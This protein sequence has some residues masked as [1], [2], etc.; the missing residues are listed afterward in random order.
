[1]IARLTLENFMAHA[2]TELELGPGV[3][4]LTGPNNVGKSAVVE[5]LRCLTQN[6]APRHVIRHG[7]KEARVS[8]ELDDG[9]R[10]VWI[11]KKAGAGYQL[12]RPGAEAPEEFWKLGRGGVPD[13]VREALRLETVA[14]ENRDDAI[15]VHLGNQRQPIFLLNEPPS[16][17]ASFFAAS[18]ESAHLLAMQDALKRRTQDA[19]RDQARA[20]ARLKDIQD[21]LDRL[22]GLPDLD[23]ALAEARDEE[24]A[25]RRSGEGIPALEDWLSR[26]AGLKRDA[27]AAARRARVLEPLAAPPAAAPTDRL[28]AL[29]RDLRFARAAR[30]SSRAKAAALS[31]L[32]EPA[33]PA[34]TARPAGMLAELRGLLRRR[35]AV[36]ARTAALAPLAEAPAPAPTARIA[37]LARGIRSLKAEEKALSG[38]FAALAALRESP[39]I[40]K[41]DALAD[42]LRRLSE[43]RAAQDAARK[44]FEDCAARLDGLRAEIAARLDAVGVCPTCGAGLDL[45]RFIRED[46]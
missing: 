4:A 2:R 25:L 15:D 6:P 43:S 27:E 13:E 10:V 35:A 3:T 33:P 38:R 12:W 32:S 26:R 18:S 21:A 16:V 7:A 39:A 30:E 34:A 36:L 40:R 5:A 42:L 44:A 45:A 22:S 19:R 37:E 1:M 17:A 46:A 11:R 29:L 41:A 14:L 8:V 20:S 24:D 28:A 31:S 9:T 23:L